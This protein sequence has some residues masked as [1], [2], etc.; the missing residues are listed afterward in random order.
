MGTAAAI[1]TTGYTAYTTYD[2]YINK[3]GTDWKVGVKAGMDLVIT[4]VGFLG[5]VGFGISTTYF[6]LDSATGGFGGF[7]E[8]PK[9]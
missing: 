4:G 7:G 1:V 6:I 9:N 3:G 2:Y 8:I 5:P